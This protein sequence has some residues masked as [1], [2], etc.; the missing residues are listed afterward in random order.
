MQTVW[1]PGIRDLAETLET[2]LAEVKHQEDLKLWHPEPLAH[3]SPLYTTVHWKNR[4]A[5]IPMQSPSHCT[6]AGW[7]GLCPACPPARQLS[8]CQ[9]ATCLTGT[10][11]GLQHHQTLSPNMPRRCRQA[12]LDSK[13]ESP[14]LLRLKFYC[15]WNRDFFFSFFFSLSICLLCCL[16]VHHLSLL[17]SLVLHL[18]SFFFFFFFLLLSWFG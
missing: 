15:Y 7:P 13:G 8:D 6:P 10:I 5:T 12:G 11:G 1:A 18:F 16:I 4:Q 2:C 9:A 17:I 14:K 3:E